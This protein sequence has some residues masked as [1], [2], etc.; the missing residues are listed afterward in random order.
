V[1]CT[2]S[3][4]FTVGY[5]EHLS[6]M[7]AT[8]NEFL[9]IS[10]TGPRTVGAVVTSGGNWSVPVTFADPGP[11]SV[12]ATL[13]VKGLANITLTAT[14]QW[15]GTA[16]HPPLSLTL[17][18][19]PQTDNLTYALQVAASSPIGVALVAYSVDSG[20][21]WTNLSQA[22]SGLWGAGP[23]GAGTVALPISNPVDPHTGSA[24]TL[25]VRGFD[26]FQ[27]PPVPTTI[28][29][30]ITARDTLPPGVDWR[31]PPDGTL[32]E[33]AGGGAAMAQ[34]T[35][36]LFVS[37]DQDGVVSAGPPTQV[38]YRID[39]GPWAALGQVTSADP[40]LWQANATLQGTGPHTL[41]VQ[42]TDPAGNSTSLT[43]TVIVREAGALTTTE[44]DYLADLIDYAGNRIKTAGPGSRA[45]T[46]LDLA[47][48]LCEPLL[49]LAGAGGAAR[50]PAV[51]ANAPINAVRGAIEVLRAYLSP[52]PVGHWPLDEGTGTAVRDDSGGGSGGQLQS[53]GWG[54]GPP[55]Q[56]AAPAFDGHSQVA[57]IGV[58][59]Q[60]PTVG[61]LTLAAWINPS[62]AAPGSGGGVIAGREGSY[63]L[64][65]MADGSVQIA[66]P[67]ASGFL[68][69]H[70]GAS[71]PLTR[72]SHVA[73]TYQGSSGQVR[74]YLNGVLAGTIAVQP[75]PGVPGGAFA[76]G[77]RQHDN[78]SFFEGSI[79][80][81]A[82]FDRVLGGYD[83]QKLTGQVPTATTPWLDGSLPAGV[84]VGTGP[85]SEPFTWTT[86]DPT[87]YSAPSSHYSPLASG[88]HEHF[89][90]GLRPG[91][92]VDRFDRLYAYVYLDP[93]HPPQEVMLQ[94]CDGAGSWE[95]RA[96][97]GQDGAKGLGTTGTESRRYAGPLPPAGQWARLEVA[98]EAVGLE[99]AFVT[100][101]GF[102]LY[103][104]QAWWDVSA[105][106]AGLASLER[107]GY[108]AA[109][110]EAL[111]TA[112]GTSLEEL[113]AAR[114]ATAATRQA[115]ADRLAITLSPTRPDELDQLLSP[116]GSVTEA[117]LA[118]MFG[119]QRT[120]AD[121]LSALAGTPRL[122]SWQQAR[123]RAQWAV[124][125]HAT[126]SAADYTPPVVDPDIVALSDILNP[127]PGQAAYD[128]WQARA[129]WVSTQIKSLQKPHAT[130][131]D[132]AANLG[133]IVTQ[134]LSGFDLA[135]TALR[136]AA[137]YDIS[138]VLDQHQLDLAG[139]SR[140]HTL[141][142]LAAADALTDDEWAD[143]CAILVEVE[144]T[145]GFPAWRKQ[146]QQ[147]GLLLDPDVFDTSAPA[148]VLPAWR[149]STTAR[150]SWQDR[151]AARAD[152]LANLQAGLDTAIAQAEQTAL[153]LLRDAALAAAAPTDPGGLSRRLC[154]DLQ[155]GQQLTTTRL[156]RAV[157]AMQGLFAGLDAGGGLT[158]V[159]LD[160]T[161]PVPSG[162][163]DLDGVLGELEWMGQ[164]SSWQSAMAVFL[165]PE[166]H[167]LPSIRPASAT[168]DAF[169]NLLSALASAGPLTEQG[170]RQMAAAYWNDASWGSAPVAAWW[171]VT[172]APPGYPLHTSAPG[173]TPDPWP[174]H[175]D[176][177]ATT[178]PVHQYPYCEL[179]SEGNLAA[180]RDKVEAAQLRGYTSLTAV[181]ARLREL[182]FDLPMQLALALAQSSQWRAA[183]AWLR[184]IFDRE[185]P[186]PVNSPVD[187]R[188]IFIG[189]SIEP[190][191][192][193]I[194]RDE[195]WLN[196]GAL[197]PHALAGERARSYLRFT[198]ITIT[199]VLCDWADAEFSTDTAESRS[200]AASLYSQ[201][202]DVLAAPELEPAAG[203]AANP[204]LA[205]LTTRA[206]MNL[207]KLRNGLNIAGLTRPISTI[208]SQGAVLVVPSPTNYRYNTLIAR[209]QQ[210][211]TLA[212]QIEAGYLASLEKQDAENYQQLLAQQDLDVAGAHVTVAAEQL[213]VAGTEID[214]ANLQVQRAQTQSDTYQAWITAGPNQYERDQLSQIGQQSTYQDWAA[215]F[216]AAGAIMQGLATAA[217]SSL[218]SFGSSFGPA[219]AAGVLNATGIEFGNQAQQAALTGQADALQ[220][221]WERRQQEWGLQKALADADVAI[222][223]QQVLA[224][225]QR[226]QV[227]GDELAVA[228]L[229]QSNA[230]AKL[231]FL[232]TKLTNAQLYAWMAGILGGVYRYL[233]QRAGAVA[234]LAEQQLAFERQAPVPGYIKSDYWSASG[235]GS[236]PSTGTAGLTGSA[237]LLE[238]IT[239]LDSYAFDTN[240]RKLQLTQT[241]SLATLAPVD[242]ERFRQTGVLPFA[243]P[244]SSFGAPGMYLAAIRT[245]RVSLA[246]LIPPGVGIRGTLSGGG[247]SHIVVDDGGTF[248][249]VTLARAPETIVLTTA[250]SAS[251]VFQVDLTPDLQLPWEGC[252]LDVPLELQVPKAINA[253]D[254]RTIADVQLS[255]DY[256]ALYSADYAARV[257]RELPSQST[258][259]ITLSLRDFPDSW[260]ALLSQAQAA[261]RLTPE[262]TD[263]L[264]ATWPLTADFFPNSLSN[265]CV[266]EITLLTLRASDAELAIAHL[267]LNDQPTDA[268]APTAATTV[269]HIVST[270]NGSGAPW[271]SPVLIG[272]NPVGTWELGLSGDPAS[273]AAVAGGDIEDL[274]LVLAYSA[275]T[276]PWPS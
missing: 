42:C 241:F 19:A 180:L 161:V 210:L 154:V 255:I 150:L 26:R 226:A 209:A 92:P 140:L 120:D 190:Q 175:A 54:T 2:V 56:A 256:T 196:A 257:I 254:Y 8:P 98:A 270:R 66:L 253:F 29:V 79:A 218:L 149:A 111:L 148:P 265:L 273:I 152:Q 50:V 237:R 99:G 67:T 167:L 135:G 117:S 75:R 32:V 221:S 130:Q 89:F 24:A 260:Y 240:T 248:S 214:V 35:I 31:T 208:A 97:W 176:P 159:D 164:Y 227:A 213:T 259:S 128:L 263:P 93:A 126:T 81:V 127:S 187:P 228:Q 108:R 53:A 242:L 134:I 30:Q 204:D 103:G 85:G 52:G 1:T 94:W 101:L 69:Q 16:E 177:K 191:T 7:P 192:E 184:V 72:W 160:W 59:P 136:H 217:G 77:A 250:A 41:A 6:T 68:F 243:I 264:L 107:C 51:L 96:F 219:V 272:A 132:A 244:V 157:E 23:T 267:H 168:T 146:E 183:L 194:T 76:I 73:V 173:G 74:A 129:Y 212:A 234:R 262:P 195:N 245:L 141:A 224:A 14:G 182:F 100:G 266:R 86:S 163:T 147:R 91:W 18:S 222:G 116:P 3:G 185:Q 142:T 55:G 62:A 155:T 169:Q 233:L 181:D 235:E 189:F 193:T 275:S 63:L 121:P 165:Y 11:V 232:Q 139:F 225:Q 118:A 122:L 131:P 206:T 216:Q 207:A 21:H 44:Q 153:P 90:S 20:Q 188:R 47:N 114:G 9:G 4:T 15:S 95:H 220:A 186:P 119:L 276:P 230:Q 246:A 83:I 34:S 80:Q 61:D 171:P 249:A 215:Q 27:S 78:Q 236:A 251:G 202:L 38:L 46:A 43:R 247:T 258:S 144:K 274:V 115:L 12:Q 229:T 49:P 145:R 172:P 105:K 10:V 231:Q 238:D 48:T 269:G 197:D 239:Q 64:A 57:Q 40:A 84:Q 137:G 5:E 151:L 88:L 261:Q 143:A 271:N 37:D 113:R 25:L 178:Y 211:I 109:A 124:A 179:L 252:G 198:L 17:A 33:I 82:V 156:D 200:L 174:P 166:S 201:A 36:T 162:Y 170:A 28:S 45:V 87:P 133:A 65:R 223:Q 158:A 268:T 138:G 22:P 125:D 104:G 112:L 13:S 71:V 70:T 199:G 39:A 123:L 102:A 60:L 203:L 110:Y 58:A 106:E 205:G